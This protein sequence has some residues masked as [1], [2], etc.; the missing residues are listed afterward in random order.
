VSWG[1]SE[2]RSRDSRALRRSGGQKIHC[3]VERD[4]NKGLLVVLGTGGEL[5]QARAHEVH[6]S[7]C[8]GV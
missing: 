5:L 7:L 4:V 6:G 1:A 8:R 3:T 2:G